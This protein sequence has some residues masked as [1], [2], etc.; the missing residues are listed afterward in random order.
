MRLARFDAGDGP[1]VGRVDPSARRVEDLSALRP[2]IGDDPLALGHAD[3]EGLT[4]GPVHDISAVRLLCPLAKP[5]AIYGVGLNYRDH[6]RELGK[7]LP[8]TPPIFLKPPNALAGPD[9]D[10]MV[11]PHDPSLDYEGELGVVIGCRLHGGDAGAAADAILGYV[12]ADDIT[13]RSLAR[14]E[15]LALAKGLAGAA[16]IGPW[17]TLRG[18]VADPQALAIRTH[19]NGELR[20]NGTTADMARSCVELVSLIARTARLEPGDL[21][22]TGS[23]SGS[24]AGF[25]PPRWLAPG[26]RVVV[27]IDGLG[28]IATTVR[29]TA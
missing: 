5:G 11:L 10:V 12:V 27:E 20:Q 7:T 22:L 18:A 24:G 23:P 21:I 26:D 1:R 3:L 15:T 29:K 6:A 16:P 13:L 28:A 9:S 19:V 17:I 8:E 4:G 2:D 25:S 14:P